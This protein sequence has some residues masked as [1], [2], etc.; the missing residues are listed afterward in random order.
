MRGVLSEVGVYTPQGV[1]ITYCVEQP[2]PL[3][4]RDSEHALLEFRRLL[5][6]HLFCGG[7]RRLVIVAF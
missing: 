1:C 7:Q 2:V 6:T 3:H 4:L 5:K